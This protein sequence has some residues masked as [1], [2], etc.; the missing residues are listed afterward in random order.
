[1]VLSAALMLSGCGAKADAADKDAA[2]S[3][4]ASGDA[5]SGETVSAQG[6]EKEVA[7]S[8]EV[9]EI[10][11]KFFIQQCNDIYYNPESY[12]GTVVKLEGIY[13]EYFDEYRGETSHAVYRNGPG[14]CGNDGVAGFVF[15]YDGAFPTQNDWVEVTGIVELE[16]YDDGFVNVILK[17]TDVD[18]KAERG[19]EF[20]KN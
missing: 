6:T 13:D 16:T 5:S 2:R 4:V 7:D 19:A 11:E 14:C 10:G 1:M 17:A 18:V 15:Q 12:E 9:L 8:E 3:D 20:V